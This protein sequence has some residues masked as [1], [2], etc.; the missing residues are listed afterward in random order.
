MTN[1]LDG[2][3]GIHRY[4]HQLLAAF[5]RAAH[6]AGIEYFLAYGTAL[7]AVRDGD[8]IPWDVDADVWLPREHYDTLVKVV[9][10][11]LPEPFTLITPETHP[12]YEYLFPR[13]SIKGVPHVFLRVDI[14]PLDPAPA[15]AAGQWLHLKVARAL[16]GVYFVKRVDTDVRNFYSWRK[17]Q[18]ARLLT[19]AVLPVRKS[20]LLAAFRRLQGLSSR[21][22]SGVL[23]N[24]CGSY[25]GRE[26]FD[27][28]WF[29]SA[30]Q[31][32]LAEHTFPVPAGHHQLLT[33][34]YGD[35]AT[36]VDKEQQAE[37]MRFAEESV[38][39]P[40]RARGLLPVR[41]DWSG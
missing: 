20:W 29:E 23:V 26:F 1:E 2:V 21:V 24:S 31:L 36:P 3:A 30:A 38:A 18:V 27:A 8:L 39:T 41:E 9:G 22:E 33:Q 28:R 32:P 16:S 14:F 40:M 37:A 35:Y 11:A 19:L 34:L 12:D 10:P 4:V 6:Q 5:D 17:R 13:L 25:G 15:S 7:G